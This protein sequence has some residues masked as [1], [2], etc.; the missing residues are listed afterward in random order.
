MNKQDE[1]LAQ[2]KRVNTAAR[3]M[4]ESA[5]RCQQETARLEA[6][7]EGARPKMSS[8][9]EAR[10]ARVLAAREALFVKK[11]ATAANL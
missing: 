8:D 4:E 7:I 5:K 9:F 2:L 11:T 10:A 1:I 6:L 3:V